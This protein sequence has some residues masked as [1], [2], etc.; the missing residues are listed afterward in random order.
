[1]VLYIIGLGLWDKEDITVKGLNALKQC[2]K[3]YLEDYTSKLGVSVQELEEFYGK[4]IILADRKTAEQ[5]AEMTI[6]DDA[7]KG[8]C[9]FLVV[10]DSLSATTHLS[11]IQAAKERGIKV[12]IVNNASILNSIAILGLELY[13]YGRTVS[14]P[15]NN[16]NV[17]SPVKF[18]NQ[19]RGIGLHTLFL[20][21]LN[22]KEGKFMQV[23]EAAKYLIGKGVRED[24]KAIGCAGIGSENPEIRYK[25]LKQL[26]SEEFTIVPQCLVIPGELHFVEEEFIERFKE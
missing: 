26:A 16:K 22:P 3:V 10:G 11:I 4:E 5:D 9:A 12:V 17:D 20:L 21:D 25:T 18:Y 8:N 15:F 6:I 24:T 2:D 23:K 1:M 7:E 14:I 13:K 19:N